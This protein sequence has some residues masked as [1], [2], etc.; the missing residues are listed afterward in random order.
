[1]PNVIVMLTFTSARWIN[2]NLHVC[3]MYK[4]NIS[5]CMRRA[6]VGNGVSV[7]D[8]SLEQPPMQMFLGLRHAFLPNGGST[9]WSFFPRRTDELEAVNKLNGRNSA[10]WDNLVIESVIEEDWREKF[11]MSRWS[12]YKWDSSGRGNF[13]ISKE[14]FEDSKYP[15]ACGRGL[16]RLT[17]VSSPFQVLSF[18]KGHLSVILT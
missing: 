8:A 17:F 18:Y 15:D 3:K 10:L 7:F 2:N 9:F 13:W 12:L 11:R 1:M 14:T 4:T 6:G 5:Y 16:S